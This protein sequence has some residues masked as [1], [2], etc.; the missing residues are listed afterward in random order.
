MAAAECTEIR[1]SQTTARQM[2]YAVADKRHQ[3]RI[4]AENPRKHEVVRSLLQKEQGHHILIIGEFLDQLKQIATLTEL[5]L[6]TGKTPKQNAIG[7]TSSSA[8]V[9]SLGSFCLVSATLP[10]ICLTPMY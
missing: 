8:P 2:E 6:V 9:K 7:A 1:I 4:A 5:P 10:S 3:F